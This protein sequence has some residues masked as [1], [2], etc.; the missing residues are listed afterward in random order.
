MTRPVGNRVGIG[1]DTEANRNEGACHS[2]SRWEK[3]NMRVLRGNGP[4][5]GPSGTGEWF[6]GHERD[7][8]RRTGKEIYREKLDRIT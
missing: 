8:V 2:L 5:Q 3:D 1:R 6:T 7:V 4:L